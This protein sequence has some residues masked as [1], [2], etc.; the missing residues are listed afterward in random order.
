MEL[1]QR[2]RAEDA[3]RSRRIEAASVTENAQR[4]ENAKRAQTQAREAVAQEVSS[5]RKLL[6]DRD[7]KSLLEEIQA[8]LGGEI[9]YQEHPRADGWDMAWSSYGLVD[10]S[11]EAPSE[12]ALPSDM[13]EIRKLL[14]KGPSNVTAWH[15]QITPIQTLRIVLGVRKRYLEQRPGEEPRNPIDFYVHAARGLFNKYLRDTYV[16]RQKGPR[17][18]RFSYVESSFD[19]RAIMIASASI[20]GGAN[21]DPQALEATHRRLSPDEEKR[22]FLPDGRI[23][24]KYF[25]LGW[26][27]GDIELN[28]RRAPKDREGLKDFLARGLLRLG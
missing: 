1:G 28:M 2:Q 21:N 18:E 12:S 8:R 16:F 19:S 25:N 3:E 7:A 24:P 11:V 27:H 9:I 14:K 17:V 20:T 5:L 22:V 4:R 23:K 13:S 10:S 6:D 26:S 15:E